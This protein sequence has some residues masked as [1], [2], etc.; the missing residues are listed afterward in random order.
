MA[1]FH[2]KDFALASYNYRNTSYSFVPDD[3]SDPQV[4]D[5]YGCFHTS[6]WRIVKMSIAK[7]SGVRCTLC[8]CRCVRTKSTLVQILQGLRGTTQDTQQ[9]SFACP[10]C[11][12]L[13]IAETFIDESVQKFEDAPGQ[14]A[15]Y[16]GQMDLVVEVRCGKKDCISPAIVFVPIQEPTINPDRLH[17]YL[18]RYANAGVRCQ[19]GHDISFPYLIG[20]I[21]SLFG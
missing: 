14:I 2:N 17:S 4:P 11:Q 16:S 9:I 10:Q 1:Y 7:L 5:T 13:V 12:Q 3:G 21:K 6:Q 19:Q 8:G 20:E 18:D 15:K